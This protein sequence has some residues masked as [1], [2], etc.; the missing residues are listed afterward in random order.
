MTLREPIVGTEDLE[1]GIVATPLYRLP[2]LLALSIAGLLLFNSQGLLDWCQR[3]PST[4]R[5]EWI[6]GRAADWHEAM[7]AAGLTRPMATA[8]NWIAG[9]EGR[10]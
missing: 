10:R 1:Q 7:Q 9:S 6:A 5:N 3:L 2:V 4:P 8:R